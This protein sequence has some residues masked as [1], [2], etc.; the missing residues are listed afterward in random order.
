MT[1]ATAPVAS[2]VT[3][4][5]TYIRVESGGPPVEHELHPTRLRLRCCLTSTYA[6]K[7]SGG[8]DP[9]TIR[10]PRRPRPRGVVRRAAPSHPGSPRRRSWSWNR[11]SP[12]L[13]L[14]QRVASK[15]GG[16]SATAVE[17]RGRT[18]GGEGHHEHRTALFWQAARNPPTKVSP[19][20]TVVGREMSSCRPGTHR[21]VGIRASSSAANRRASSRRGW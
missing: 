1:P 15:V 9:A 6:A 3:R 17:A 7:S 16:L 2:A 20:P 13:A 11:P 18:V 12:P 8:L 10:G 14:T 19:S 21:T 5:V 4:A